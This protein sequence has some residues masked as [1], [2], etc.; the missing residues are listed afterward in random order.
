MG[1]LG[2]RDGE[3]DLRAIVVE[4]GTL[5][6]GARPRTT[7]G[8]LRQ[9]IFTASKAGDLKKVRSLQKLMLRSRSGRAGERAGGVTEVNA[10]PQDGRGSTA[11]SCWA[12]WEKG[13]YGGLAPSVA[14]AAWR[15]LPVK[16]GVHPESRRG[17]FAGSGIPT[18]TAYCAVCASRL[19]FRNPS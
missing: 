5:W 19:R 12:G 17:N 10:G 13:R 2:A 7:Y 6:T 4:L 1:K 16:A 11:G 8:G 18:V 9:R 14:R 3:R 15:P